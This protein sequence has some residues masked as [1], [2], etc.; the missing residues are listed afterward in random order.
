MRWADNFFSQ[1]LSILKLVVRAPKALCRSGVVAQ[2]LACA[3]HKAERS[4]ARCYSQI[5]QMSTPVGWRPSLPL[6][7]RWG[8]V[9]A[10]HCTARHLLLINWSFLQRQQ[11]KWLKGTSELQLPLFLRC[12]NPRDKERELQT[13]P[14][15]QHF[16]CIPVLGTLDVVSLTAWCLTLS[17]SCTGQVG[18]GQVVLGT[19]SFCLW[20]GHWEVRLGIIGPGSLCIWAFK[21][22]LFHPNIIV[23]PNSGSYSSWNAK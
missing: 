8:T 13:Q 9:P 15:F 14:L 2:C 1:C 22:F 23:N 19:A 4:C 12:L 10:Y 6:H 21:T 16:L 7:E 17:P 11:L 3:Q 18:E 20:A 5:I